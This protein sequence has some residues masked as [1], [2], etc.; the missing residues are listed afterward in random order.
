MVIILTV[1][2]DEM[3]GKSEEDKEVKSVLSHILS[4]V[5]LAK[6]SSKIYCI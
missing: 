3:M 4:R 6:C 2:V 1:R 5:G